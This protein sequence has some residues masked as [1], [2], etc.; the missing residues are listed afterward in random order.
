MTLSAATPMPGAS[1]RAVASLPRC[2]R[3]VVASLA[4][5]LTVVVTAVAGP[6]RPASAEEVA[7]PAKVLIV[8]A[9]SLTWDRTK[10]Q[11]PT[12]WSFASRGSVASMSTRTAGERSDSPA[13]Y[14][15]VGSGRRAGSSD[16]ATAGAAVQR[17]GPGGDSVVVA[18]NFSAQVDANEQLRYGAVPGALGQALVG[19]GR[20]A[21]PVGN[22]GRT[23]TDVD[24]RAVAL[25]AVARDGTAPGGAV[26]GDLLVAD[27]AAPFG[28]RLDVERVVAETERSL[29]EADVVVLELSDL[30]RA[31]QAA[32]TDPGAASGWWA[33]AAS[34]S[35]ALLAGVLGLVDPSRDLVLVA[36]P[37]PPSDR[38]ALGVFAAQGPGV[39]HGSAR[40]ATTRR[41][42]FVTLVDLAPTVLDRLGVPI[43][44]TIGDTPISFEPSASPVDNGIDSF[45]DTDVEAR[46]R[47]AA[48]GPITVAMVL[49]V[50]IVAFA[51]MWVRRRGGR[52]A[53]AVRA[54]CL[55][56][57][58]YPAA[59]F[60]TG[61]WPGASAGTWAVLVVVLAVA[62]LIGALGTWVGR[63]EDER[64]PLVVSV[65]TVLVL[66]VDVLT[67][68][69]L[70]F[71]T[72]FGYS[73]IVAGRFAGF[74]NV[75]FSFLSAS[76]VIAASAATALA[77]RAGVASGRRVVLTAA[78]FAAAVVVVGA[79]SFG[80]DV[81]GVIALV[82]A[83]IVF[84]V[85]AGSWRPRS[86]GAVG[87][88]AGSALLTAVVLAVFAYWDRSRP[89]A[90]RTHLG[91]LVDD[92]A[93]G[94]LGEV[95]QRK[96]DANVTAFTSTPWS[97]VIPLLLVGVAALVWLPGGRRAALSTERPELR[98]F[99]ASFVTLAV[100]AWVANDSGVAL[101]AAML[102]LA[103]PYLSYL[104]VRRPDDEVARVDG[105][106]VAGETT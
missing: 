4:A 87:V 64:G 8:M 12:L 40:S 76:V 9:P 29:A 35:D 99:A 45:I 75:A 3:V 47:D 81:G 51:A 38:P 31:D 26:G 77:A 84:L 61:V 53:T 18:P 97:L 100:L 34:H 23:T 92:A 2:A 27:P 106:P 1:G 85:V 10:L 66:A 19:A 36:S 30:E 88:I 78:W 56:T 103:V 90:D 41:T 89:A 80:S 59:A 82:P 74:G 71:D 94:R 33:N 52:A 73:P 16:P 6:V 28:V 65:L 72:P 57:M 21:V 7:P 25:S 95:L 79:P 68:A 49:L 15:T 54:L 5:A 39:P 93:S 58:A 69:R 20:V 83:A 105:G 96:L 67:G 17:V 42:G 86:A 11:L 62:A 32:A 43:P 13:G 104:A 50:T 37:T 24:H 70:Q 98:A 55:V 46:A 102:G 44:D 48:T 101:P 60:L 14:L 22:A 63:A 91:R